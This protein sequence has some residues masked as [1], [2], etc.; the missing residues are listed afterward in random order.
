MS[1]KDEKMNDNKTSNKGYF[2]FGWTA[3]VAFIFLLIGLVVGGFL[4]IKEV[5]QKDKDELKCDEKIDD[6]KDKDVKVKNESNN[7]E[8]T[9]DID[10]IM[11]RIQE[12]A[13]IEQV[14]RNINDV[15]ELTNQ[16]LLL[17]AVDS[18]GYEDSI[19]KSEIEDIIEKYFG[20]SVVFENINCHYGD[21]V[22]PP[23]YL[24]DSK[25]E[26]FVKN[27][28]HGAHGIGD[29]YA[30]ILNRL[31][32]YKVDGNLY[33]IRVK[34]AFAMKHDTGFPVTYYKTYEDAHN[35]ENV[36]FELKID[37]YEELENY[38]PEDDFNN[39]AND[40]LVTYEYVFEKNGNNF[41]LKSYRIGV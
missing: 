20:R 8:N 1:K 33:V 22:E 34:K 12:L 10:L 7:I 21:E 2:G 38:N 18:L 27:E 17:F 6:K 36:L 11:I 16:E 24:Y 41:I 39:I 15:S 5:N 40:D 30:D 3:L 35:G 23:L 32:E 26:E 29:Y 19:K 28:E 31:V 13:H 14:N 37:S 4:T 25:K 9:S